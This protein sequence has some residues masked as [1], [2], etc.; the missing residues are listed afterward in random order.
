[1]AE[2]TISQ[3]FEKLGKDLGS[4]GKIEEYA[5][6]LAS[7][8]TY[9]TDINKV[10]TQTRQRISEIQY[11]IADA[12]PGVNR[13][14]GS[15]T[16]VAQTIADIASA[17]RRNVIANSESV[18]ELYASS[19]LLGKSAEELTNKFLDVG[20]GFDKIG[21]RLEES[22]S[23]V[24]SI[25]GN[26]AEVMRKVV[27]NT[28]QLNRFN[29]EGGVIGLTK[30]AAQASM[31][32][33]NMNETFQ[34]A[35]RV[36]DPEKAIEVASAFQRLGVASG[37][38]VDPFQLMNQAIND[39]SGLQDSLANIAKTFAS[40]NQ[41]TQRFEIS[42]QGVFTLREMEK[43]AGLTQGSLSKMAVA[44]AEV[45][46]R[47][48][49]I[50]P[51][52][53][54]ENEEDKQYLANIASLEDGKYMVTLEDDTKKELAELT[55]PELNKLIEEQKKGPK[56]IEEIQRDQ[57]GFSEIMSADVT[58][59]KNKLLYGIV[60]SKPL[61]EGIEGARRTMDAVAG[62]ASQP[63]SGYMDVQD[64]RGQANRFYGN[65]EQLVKDVQTGGLS[66]E[67]L[68]KYVSANEKQI[69]ELGSSFYNG[70]EKFTNEVGDKLTNKTPVEDFLKKG[71]E[72]LNQTLIENKPEKIKAEPLGRGL[73]EGQNRTMDQK[74]A[75]AAQQ[76]T[77]K[78]EVNG[79][80]EVDIKLP[81]DFA[82]LDTTQQQQF[83][84]KALNSSQFMQ[85]VN[86]IMTSKNANLK[87][88]TN[89]TYTR[90]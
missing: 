22:I 13:L 66:A 3:F 44:A 18:E 76:P 34:L 77:S 52:L 4:V 64:V 14:G 24:Q 39:P 78:V 1:M 29:F 55:Q 80:V 35:D 87:A 8:G 89:L 58:A 62:T 28:E 38:M 37:T 46:A 67:S 53:K 40:F 65:I 71:F 88:P 81:A 85:Y 90:A 72:N 86:N 73:I 7:L 75:E 26:A 5:N 27:D 42:R 11:S 41:E 50:S 68:T 12:V 19:K 32:R 36:L 57:L 56:T 16:D 84:D 31:L 47:L 45:D 54:F 10:F 23:Y 20:I 33:F 17:S 60:S 49:Q 69:R 70:L 43:E 21:D 82:K 48:T 51:S 74:A 2:E 83:F 59:I 15:V 63:R 61:V 79:K 6:A 30:M 25:G 9:S